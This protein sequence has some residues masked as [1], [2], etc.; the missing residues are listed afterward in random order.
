MGLLD[1]LFGPSSDDDKN[2]GDQDNGGKSSDNSPEPP[3][4]QETWD[5]I[6]EIEEA[7]KTDPEAVERWSAVIDEF[8]EQHPDEEL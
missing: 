5:S 2:G 1:D 8:N 6:A 7:Q 3:L 4:G